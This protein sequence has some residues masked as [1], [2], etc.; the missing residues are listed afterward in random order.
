MGQFDTNVI[1]GGE[2]IQVV[3]NFNQFHVL[4]FN[5]FVPFQIA[6]KFM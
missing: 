5:Q 6:K 1:L 4:M 2:F 3:I